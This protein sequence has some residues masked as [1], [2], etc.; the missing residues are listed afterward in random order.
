[1]CCCVICTALF[2]DHFICARASWWAPG[3]SQH[4]G[5][6]P[7]PL[8]GDKENWPGDMI[9][10][11]NHTWSWAR[12]LFRI[13]GHCHYSSN[14]FRRKEET[15]GYLLS[16]EFSLS[17]V[18]K[19]G[20]WRK[21]SSPGTVQALLAEAP[22]GILHSKPWRCFSRHLLP[23]SGDHSPAKVGAVWKPG[24]CENIRWS[25]SGL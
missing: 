22:S 5:F 8:M 12:T 23:S 11:H 18:L 6:R 21:C 19:R 24:W 14:K 2:T 7:H 4:T 3:V 13:K 17:T 9:Y 25:L 10:K 20:L 15:R 16:G 1:M